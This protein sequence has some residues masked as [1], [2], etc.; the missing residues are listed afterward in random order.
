MM[1]TKNPRI[2]VALEKPVFSLIERIAEKRGLS[3]SIVARDLIW[4]ALEIHEGAVFA[5]VVEERES[6]PVGRESLKHDEV[7][8][9]SALRGA[10]SQLS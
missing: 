5:S 9:R 3:L 4:E 2:N 1:P 6:T 10:L 8:Q 7:W